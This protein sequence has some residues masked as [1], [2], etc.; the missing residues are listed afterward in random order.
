MFVTQDPPFVKAANDD[1]PL[2]MS[3]EDPIS[4]IIEFMAIIEETGSVEHVTDLYKSERLR[5]KDVG[6]WSHWRKQRETGN[7]TSI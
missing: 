3:T 7:E 1:I 4:E 2:I 6:F 5:D